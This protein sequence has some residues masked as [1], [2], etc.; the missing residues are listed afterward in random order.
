VLKACANLA[1]LATRERPERFVSDV[2][3]SAHL[4]EIG[5]PLCRKY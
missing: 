1:G 4:E 2:Q 5:S 3:I